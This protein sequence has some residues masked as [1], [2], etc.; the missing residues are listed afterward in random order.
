MDSN[1][2]IESH[3]FIAINSLFSGDIKITG[4]IFWQKAATE[5]ALEEEHSSS[6]FCETLICVVWSSMAQ[7]FSCYKR[8]KD[9]LKKTVTTCNYLEIVRSIN[10]CNISAG[11]RSFYQS[12]HYFLLYFS[13]GFHRSNKL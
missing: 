10:I 2:F 7:S 1:S 8:L 9:W 12:Q 3:L 5:F 6:L 13:P 11:H 4:D